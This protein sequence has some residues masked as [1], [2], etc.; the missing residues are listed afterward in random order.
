MLTAMSVAVCSCASGRVVKLSGEEKEKSMDISRSY[1]VLAASS[2]IDVTYSSDAGSLTVRADSSILP[3]VCVE[4]KAG[5]L[6][7]Y[8][9]NKEKLK[10][11]NSDPGS[12]R[13][14][15]PSSD[16][17]GKIVISGAVD[18]RSDSAI[19]AENLIVEISGA[20]DFDADL[21][22]KSG[23]SISLAGASDIRSKVSADLLELDASGASDAKVSGKVNTYKLSASGASSVS[24][25]KA[26][27]ETDTLSCDISGASDCHVQ[28]NVSAD[29]EA[30]GASRLVVYGDGKVRVATSGA[31]DIRYR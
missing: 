11:F 16:A 3:Y 26:Y 25:A 28:C 21:N 19:S 13:V 9:S 8:V 18:F 22:V 10:F 29:G 12:I 14:L 5:K 6:M 20:S 27:V 1:S 17:L 7:L 24:S 30:S 4:E 15:V 23:L 31:S 2:A